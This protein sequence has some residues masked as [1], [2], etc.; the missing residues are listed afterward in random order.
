M[1]KKPIITTGW[2]GHIDFL[3]KD[4]SILLGGTLK[5]VDQSAVN[6]WIINESEWFN[7]D[8][9]SVANGIMGL[10]TDYNTWERKGKTQGTNN[11]KKY[12]LDKM[13]ERIDE[14]LNNY[15]PNF[16]KQVELNLP[17]LNLPKLEK[18]V[19]DNKPNLPK[20]KLPKLEK[21]NNE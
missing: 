3:D 12:S 16:P 18:V 10:F 13:Q 19:E 6:D 9:Q 15:I 5:K 17:K 4:L 11:I 20:L 14:V 1:V 21:I 8:L 7:V 2:S